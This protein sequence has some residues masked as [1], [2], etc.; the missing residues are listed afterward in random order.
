MATKAKTS[1][2][3]KTPKVQSSGSKPNTTRKMGKVQ[4]YMYNVGKSITYAAMDKVKEMNPVLSEFSEK[5]NDLFKVIYKSAIDY[6]TTYKRGLDAIKKTKFYEAADVG[7]TSLKEDIMTGNLYN[8][9]R[10]EKYELKAMG[11]DMDDN[12]MGVDLGGLDDGMGDLNLDDWGSFD[13]N[14]DDEDISSDYGNSADDLDDTNETAIT[15]SI[16]ATSSANA[17]A[18]SMAVARSAEYTGEV[19]IKNTNLLY[20]QN[21]KAFGAMNSNLDAMNQNIGSIM[22]YLDNN[23][24]PH[25][26]NSAEFFNQAT[27]ALQDQTALLREIAENTRKEDPNKDKDQNGKSKKKLTYGDMV[28]ANGLPEFAEYGKKIGKNFSNYIDEMSGGSY[29]M[30]M[31]GVG[32]GN[33]LATMAANPYGMLLNMLMNKIVP[34]NIDK[35]SKDLNKSLGGFFGSLITKFNTMAEDEEGSLA[36]Q[37]IG[38]IFGIRSSK[39]YS[40]D[41]SKYEKG[42]VDWD[43]ES[44]KA[45][46]EIIPNQLSEIKSILSGEEATTY[47]YEK[48]KFVTMSELKKEYDNILDSFYKNA[49]SDVMNEL[50]KLARENITFRDKDE[51]DVF[52]KDIDRLMKSLYDQNKLLDINNKELSQQWR[53]YGISSERNFAAIQALVQNIDK[54]LWHQYNNNI[55]EGYQKQN[56][57]MNE[58]ERSGR[59]NV[60]FNNSNSNE[61]FANEID[62]KKNKKKIKTIFNDNILLTKDKLGHDIFYY[63]QRMYKEINYVRRYGVG[64]DGSPSPQNINNPP[65]IDNRKI[66]IEGANN[67]QYEGKIDIED[68]S[69]NAITSNLIKNENEGKT[70]KENRERDKKQRENEKYIADQKK[71]IEVKKEKLINLSEIDDDEKVLSKVRNNIEENKDLEEIRRRNKEQK[72]KKPN[73][74]EKA[75]ETKDLSEKTANFLEKTN[76]YLKQPMKFLED[77]LSK[78]DQRL[79]ELIY[80]K[81]GIGKEKDIHGFLD[82]MLFEMRRSFNRFNAFMDEKILDPLK[83]KLGIEKDKGL[84]KGLLEKFDERFGLSDKKKNVTDRFKEIF[85]SVKDSITSTAKEIGKTVSDTVKEAITPITG[86]VKEKNFFK[87]KKKEDQDKDSDEDGENDDDSSPTSSADTVSKIRDLRNNYNDDVFK[88]ASLREKIDIAGNKLREMNRPKTAKEKIE[89]AKT[90]GKYIYDRT[91]QLDSETKNAGVIKQSISLKKKID[92]TQYKYKEVKNEYIKVINELKSGKVKS[93]E[94]DKKLKLQASLSN[95]MSGISAQLTKYSNEYKKLQA[96]NPTVTFQDIRDYQNKLEDIKSDAELYVNPDR[97][98]YDKYQAEYTN[99]IIQFINSEEFKN[100]SA[101]DKRKFSAQIIEGKDFDIQDQLKDLKAERE[102]LVA[103]NKQAAVDSKGREL[104]TKKFEQ[105]QTPNKPKDYGFETGKKRGYDIKVGENKGGNEIETNYD[106]QISNI[107][108]K[109]AE[110]EAKEKNNYKFNIQDGIA[111]MIKNPDLAKNKEFISSISKI[112]NLSKND[113]EEIEN[114]QNLIDVFK[115]TP[116]DEIAND[117]YMVDAFNKFIPELQKAWQNLLKQSKTGDYSDLDKVLG[118]DKQYNLDAKK[119][120]TDNISKLNLNSNA[121]DMLMKMYIMSANKLNSNNKEEFDNLTLEDVLY[122]FDDLHQEKLNKKSYYEGQINDLRTKYQSETNKDGSNKY[123]EDI[124]EEKIKKSSIFRKL[125][126]LNKELDSF[127][128]N[129]ESII[130]VFGLDKGNKDFYIDGYDEKGKPII[131]EKKVKILDAIQNIEGE[132]NKIDDKL[133]DLIDGYKSGQSEFIN[134]PEFAEDYMKQDIDNTSNIVDI[135]NNILEELKKLTSGG[136]QQPYGPRIDN[137]NLLNPLSNINAPNE[138]AVVRNMINALTRDIFFTITNYFGRNP[139]KG[140]AKGGI[141][142]SDQLAVVGKGE[143]IL[144][145]DQKIKDEQ[146]KIAK[147]DNN[148]VSYVAEMINNMNSMRF[149]NQSIHEKANYLYSRIAEQYGSENIDPNL[150][151]GLLG[152]ANDAGQAFH[153]LKTEQEMQDVIKMIEIM[154]SAFRQRNEGLID[155]YGVST[156]KG[157]TVE[158]ENV[159]S[160]TFKVYQ[161]T[162]DKTLKS[163]LGEDPEKDKEKSFTAMENILKD[164]KS[165]APDLISG[166]LLGAGVS[167]FTG[168]LGGPLLGAAVGAGVS[169]TKRS[170]SLQ[171]MLFGE[172]IIDKDGNVAGRKGGIIPKDIVNKVSEVAPDLKK[173]GITGAVAGLLPVLPFGPIPGLLLG[174]GVAFAKNNA[175][176]QDQLFG[177]MGIL[178]KKGI[179]DFKTKKLPNILAGAGIGGVASIL[180]LTGPFGLVGSALIGSSLGFASTTEK[181]QN[182]VFGEYDEETGQYNGGIVPY[183]RKHV[184]DP[185]VDKGKSA[186]ETFL[187]WVKRDILSPLV[188]AFK[189]LT[190]MFQVTVSDIIT[191]VGNV[192]TFF[193]KERFVIPITEKIKNVLDIV[194]SPFKKIGKMMFRAVGKV[195]S[196]PF[197]AIGAAGR[198]SRR[199]LIERGRADDMTAQ[200]R[201]DY[202]NEDYNQVDYFYNKAQE[203]KVNNRTYLVNEVKDRFGRKEALKLEGL[204]SIGSYDKARSLIDKNFGDIRDEESIK[205]RDRMY[206]KIQGH[207][208]LNGGRIS[209]NT[210]EEKLALSN[211]IKDQYV[212]EWENYNKDRDEE[213]RIP[214]EE[215]MQMRETDSVPY[216]NRKYIGQKKDELIAATSNDTL[217]K[218]SDQYKAISLGDDEYKDRKVQS[219][220]NIKKLLKTMPKDDRRTMLSY[221]RSGQY[222]NANAFL[223][224]AM[225]AKGVKA[226]DYDNYAKVRELISRHKKQ[227]EFRKDS[228]NVRNQMYQALRGVFGEDVD[229]KTI[230][231]YMKRVDAELKIR[232]KRGIVISDEEQAKSELAPEIEVVNEHVDKVTDAINYSN[233]TMEKILDLMQEKFQG[234]EAVEARKKEQKRLADL[235]YRN[236]QSLSD[237]DVKKD[238]LLKQLGYTWETAPPSLRF[239]SVSELKDIVKNDELTMSQSKVD[240]ANE[241]GYETVP[242]FMRHMSKEQLEKMQQWKDNMNKFKSDVKDGIN[243]ELNKPKVKQVVKPEAANKDDLENTK[244]VN[245][246][247]EPEQQLKPLTRNQIKEIMRDQGDD[248]VIEKFKFLQTMGLT[249]DDMPQVARMNK[250]Q[251]A[252]WSASFKKAVDNKDNKNQPKTRDQ[253]VEAL[254]EN[255]NFMIEK[256]KFL[257]SINLTFDQVPEVISMDKERF[258]KWSSSITKAMKTVNKYGNNEDGKS[259]SDKLLEKKIKILDKLQYDTIPDYVVPMSEPTFDKWVKKISNK[260]GIDINKDTSKE[261]LEDTNPIKIQQETTTSTLDD[262]GNEVVMKKDSKTGDMEADLSDSSTRKSINIAQRL[263]EKQEAFYDSFHN[264][265]KKNDEET[266]K[267]EKSGGILGK[268]LMALGIGKSMLGKFKG[269]LGGS[270]GKGLIGSLF[271]RGIFGSLGKGALVLGGLMYLPEILDLFKSHIAPAISEAWQTT[272]KPW[273]KEEA[274]PRV[275]SGIELLIK[276]L[277]SLIIGAAKFIIKAIP[278]AITGIGEALG[279]T[280]VD[281]DGEYNAKDGA[282]IVGNSATRSIVKKGAQYANAVK[283]NIGK[284]IAEKGGVKVMAETGE[285]SAAK[286]LL[287]IG[288]KEGTK[289]T[290]KGVI[291][292]AGNA[293]FHPFKT[294]A[295]GSV[296]ATQGITGFLGEQAGKAFLKVDASIAKKVARKD[297]TKAVSAKILNNVADSSLVG[298]AINGIKD[299]LVQIFTNEKVVSL[300]GKVKNVPIAKGLLEKFVPKVLELASKGAAKLSGTVLA[301][302]V[303]GLG[304]GGIVTAGFAVYDFISGFNDARNILGITDDPTIGQRIMAAVLKTVQGISIIATLI[305]TKT[306]MNILIE[307]LDVLGVNVSDIQEKQESAKQELEAYN[308]ENGTD[309]SLEEYNKEVKGHKGIFG[310]ALDGVKWVGSKVADGAK[311]AIGG[312]KSTGEKAF[313]FGKNIGQGIKSFGTNMY[314]AYMRGSDIIGNIGISAVT[315]IGEAFKNIKDSTMEL[316]N[317]YISPV[318]K[319]ASNFFSGIQE[320][321]DNIKESIGN[322]GEAIMEKIEWFKNLSPG[323]LI[324]TGTEKVKSFLGLD[325]QPNN[326]LNTRVDSVNTVNGMSYGTGDNNIKNT[327]IQNTPITEDNINN[328]NN[329]VTNTIAKNTSLTKEDINQR[330]SNLINV[331]DKYINEAK[332]VDH[333]ILSENMVASS[334]TTTTVGKTLLKTG[335]K[336]IASKQLIEKVINKIRDILYY[337]LESDTIVNLLGID[338]NG[339]PIAKKVFDRFIPK[340]IEEIATRLG[341]SSEELIEKLAKRFIAKTVANFTFLIIDF[342][343]GYQNA[344]AVLGVID[345]ASFK[346]KVIAGLIEAFKGLSI[347]SI[348]PTDIV[349]S[350]AFDALEA[351]G[352]NTGNI[353]QRRKYATETVNAYNISNDTSYTVA[354]YNRKILGRQGLISRIGD[355][356]NNLFG[357][358]RKS[359]KGAPTLASVNNINGISYGNGDGNL[360]NGNPYF[361]QKEATGGL[362]KMI[363][364]S[365]CGPTATAMALSKVTGKEIQPEQIASDALKNG[366][367][368]SE[369]ARGKMF[370]TEASKY[371]VKTIDSGGDFDKFD[372]LVSAGIPTA[373]SGTYGKG[374]SPYTSAGHIVTVFGKDENG[375]YLVNDPRGKQYSKAYS[376]EELMNGFRNSWSFGKGE[377]DTIRSDSIPQTKEIFTSAKS[378]QGKSLGGRLYKKSSNA[379]N[380][381]NN[382]IKDTGLI[383]SAA[384]VIEETFTKILNNETIIS[385]LGNATGSEYSAAS[386]LLAS[387]VPQIIK[388]FKQNCEANSGNNLSKY[389]RAIIN[390]ASIQNISFLISNFVNAFNNPSKNLGRFDTFTTGMKVCSAIMSII[391]NRF[392]IDKILPA[393]DWMKLIEDYVMP[394]FGESENDIKS[395]KSQAEKIVKQFT[396]NASSTVA[397]KNSLQSIVESGSNIGNSLFSKIGNTIS[398]VG[399]TVTSKIKSVASNVGNFV[400]NVGSTIGSAFSGAL[401]WAKG[402]FGKGEYVGRGK[403]NTQISEDNNIAFGL[404]NFPYYSQYEEYSGKPSLSE[405]GCGPTSAAMVLS[406]ITGK[407]ILPTDIADESYEAGLYDSKGSTSDLFPYIGSKYG[408]NVESTD[409]FNKVRE[410]AKRGIP[411]VISGKGGKLYGTN[412]DGHI[413][414]TFGKTDQG[415]LVNDPSSFNKSMYNENLLRSGFKEAWIFGD[416]GF[417]EDVKNANKI[418]ENNIQDNTDDI[419]GTGESVNWGYFCDPKKGAIT[420]YFK[421]KRSQYGNAQGNHGAIDYNVHFQSLYAPKSGTVYSENDHSSY[422]NNLTIKTNSGDTYYRLAHMKSKAVK[423]GEKVTQGQYLGKSGDTGHVTGPHVHFEVLKGGTS[424]Y[425][426]GVDPLD[427]YGTTKYNGGTIVTLKNSELSFKDYMNKIGSDI[428]EVNDDTS[429]SDTTSTDTSSSVSS[430]GSDFFG[431]MGSAAVNFTK[432]LFGFEVDS[433]N[434]GLADTNTEGDNTVTEDTSAVTE[435][436]DSTTTEEENY[437]TGDKVKLGSK[438]VEYALAFLNKGFFYSQPKRDYINKNKNAADCSSFTNHVYNRAAGVDIG[439][440]TEAQYT[441]KGSQN[442]G[443]KDLVPS[444]V[445]LFKNTVSS[446]YKDGV[447]HAALYIGEDRYIHST[448]NSK[449]NGIKVS[450]LGS[451][452]S[453]NHFLTGKRYVDPGKMVDPKVKNPNKLA[454]FESAKGA[455]NIPELSSVGTVGSDDSST[456]V[457]TPASSDF[458]SDMATATTNFAKKLFGFDIESTAATTG[459]SNL[460]AGVSGDYLGKYGCY[461]ET[462]GQPNYASTGSSWGDYDS[463]GI[464]QM[465]SMGN[466]SM[467]GRFRDWTQKN[468][469]SLAPYFKGT[470]VGNR[471][472][473]TFTTAWKKAASE[474]PNE[475]IDAQV[476]FFTSPGLF[477]QNWVSKLKSK[478]NFNAESDRAYQE[479]VVGA[480][481][482]GYYQSKYAKVFDQG[483]SGEALVRAFLK[484]RYSERSNK[485]YDK[486]FYD[487]FVSDNGDIKYLKQV[488]GKPAIAYGYSDAAGKGEKD[489]FDDMN[490]DKYF[491]DTLGA[492]KSSDFGIRDNEFHSGVDYAA[493]EDTPIMSPVSGKVV[494][495]INDKKYGFGNTLVIRDNKGTDHRFAHMRDQSRYGLGS[496][497]RRN[498]IIGNVGSTGRSTGSHLHYEVSKNGTSVNPNKYHEKAIGGSKNSLEKVTLSFPDSNQK[499]DAN[500]SNYGKGGNISEETLIKLVNIIITLLTKISDNTLNIEKIINI[501]T[502]IQ[503]NGISKSD[504]NNKKKSIN[505]NTSD[506]EKSKSSKL[507][508]TL[509]KGLNSSD[510]DITNTNSILDLLVKLASE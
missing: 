492:E 375:N 382:S 125:E 321:F 408:V 41:S 355:G 456:A 47:D 462:S 219:M 100:M 426:N 240:L 11:M 289:V 82:A 344:E 278:S 26:S 427:Y 473:L 264:L 458:F 239:K 54:N 188:K 266:D 212:K 364:D 221:L 183:I 236:E 351:A 333:N 378:L 460:Q 57:R 5:N 20:T 493:D 479:M 252:K 235:V 163:F 130:N 198:A 114:I 348:I 33:I 50:Y 282:K 392:V 283:G 144:P 116:S 438:I 477:Y 179:D 224:L 80:G 299:K 203:Q 308:K 436:T 231:N 38:K 285:K 509:Q 305:P 313:E 13:D 442:V 115:N 18:I 256:Y 243:E 500:I 97:D 137:S 373:V 150:I 157:T 280:D 187:G 258:T 498:D 371:G 367:W 499:V 132:P 210:Y 448:T 309:Y 494:E 45:L 160:N 440:Y 77:V 204:L 172:Q 423:K 323:N 49:G 465:A 226:G 250:E 417:I 95:K 450:D 368:D 84:F 133:K 15:N 271:S 372:K 468:Y 109:I 202:M 173:F 318:F 332:K 96:D 281:G 419:Y 241:K 292:T 230:A 161:R 126:I 504:I 110:L 23:L 389:L 409:D 475:L 69:F 166:S 288:T 387:F 274:I 140:Y 391:N 319:W 184:F 337:V 432:K 207:K 330:E 261:A 61:K 156:E 377:D 197:R 349:I 248:F 298:N 418:V 153:G 393:S 413:V 129:Y 46:T 120:M 71:R 331:G 98:N 211:K 227:D 142:D 284:E 422:G 192:I 28:D 70:T 272:I 429:S 35:L 415:Y 383:E 425:N 345:K 414:A 490:I 31:H 496:K 486:A 76:H 300:L 60:L 277:P 326:N 147:R 52:N 376:K 48:G 464:Y 196:A 32:E 175:S 200:E 320:K 143:Q 505:K 151:M 501:L 251:Y 476:K 334:F 471:S 454:N 7:L 495:N 255:D 229:E 352:I 276:E 208:D 296:K 237:K 497:I 446:G 238:E 360:V 149:K 452:W 324:K 17:N 66:I 154:Q 439:G 107:D 223:E 306:L 117:R 176:I 51:A 270:L 402:L 491:E 36:S 180:G 72:D 369:G 268:L 123:S 162:I 453:K 167:L 506:T 24:S 199:E 384:K 181:F 310:K 385:L 469:P 455:Y 467:P 217:K 88:K 386:T 443:I 242:A 503:S 327:I 201:L 510:F 220:K 474:K 174:T 441:R 421:E 463:F 113:T 59:F 62:G 165:Y 104:T 311:W 99:A 193:F 260:K 480:A 365:G 58:I 325:R 190:K 437:G 338:E 2:K 488:I 297:G 336:S 83:D 350:F 341:K 245:G 316:F 339:N 435:E 457:E 461:G 424:K 44:R 205:V 395:I 10:A 254:K 412:S 394:I 404:N 169:L 482:N 401:S 478:H 108:K 400:S 485:N 90:K 358:N 472:G 25:I 64:T 39:K 502:D 75:M 347:L 322:F 63:L 37:A 304:T 214:F 420:S 128:E 155:N 87:Q 411:M 431:D 68:T 291:K 228:D 470:K 189:P 40:I 301:R 222:D 357:F 56:E 234:K 94:L 466:D 370:S 363:S 141:I 483:L 244:V 195:I 303:G 451:N 225:N 43:G 361:S 379:M 410:Y 317:T 399:S 127:E 122:N 335:V 390:N 6:R 178:D 489:P 21:V 81:E 273:L 22:Q 14:W 93:E 16:E 101:E 65:M 191:G 8:K 354:E 353:G 430:S 216:F 434:S 112:L 85:G 262:E 103:K 9:E 121:Q 302:V 290:A 67:Q 106:Y 177:D 158:H 398:N 111:S 294:M 139:I 449:G 232:N 359:K 171:D 346:E 42:K 275:K 263:R 481:A 403:T 259:V 19:S 78:A 168:L 356:I 73:L 312:I 79:F 1:R 307:S 213:D 246:P 119:I 135:T 314:N 152:E 164:A 374:D 12:S 253:I 340:I 206:E 343:N 267:E 145:L 3:N 209:A 105:I 215:F 381:V 362:S 397:Q 380:I 148:V 30:L 182:I 53:D 293:I 257:Q 328:A 55:N 29:N 286:Q 218:I 131:K 269:L 329:A 416:Q 134:N 136:N 247:T 405:A 484:G 27:Q 295:K 447:S 406:K 407:T 428:V 91:Q 138:Q 146:D 265:F 118:I 170:S 124:I 279:W 366:S 34:D 507:L 74:L 92:D 233:D 342:A 388:K 89:E 433:T 194:T 249:F 4:G 445:I 508:N 487:R 159:F 186:I 86:A 315:G 396:I 459:D 444:D 102:R 287:K 185:L